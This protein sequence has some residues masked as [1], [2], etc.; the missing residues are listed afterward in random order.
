MSQRPAC[1]RCGAALTDEVDTAGVTVCPG[2]GKRWQLTPDRAAI[3]ATTLEVHD[4]THDAA[5]PQI[6]DR[7]G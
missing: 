1:N 2:C 6:G 5:V 3:A 4:A 7:N